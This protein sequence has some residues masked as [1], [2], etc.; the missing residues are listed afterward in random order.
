M[1]SIEGFSER[2]RAL[3]EILG[4]QVAWW[5]LGFRARRAV[6]RQ[7]RSGNR[8]P[9]PGIWSV[10]LG[11]ARH[12]LTA[13]LWWRR[14]RLAGATVLAIIYLLALAG[15]WMGADPFVAFSGALAICLPLAA[16]WSARQA[17]VARM[18]VALAPGPRP[19]RRSTLTLAIRTAGL[20]LSVGL[21]GGVVV[22]SLAH[23]H[24]AGRFCPPFAVDAPVRSWLRHNDGQTGVGCPAGDT[25]SAGGGARYTPWTAPD[26]SIR[27]GPDYV[28][29]GP[30][31]D[32]LMVMPLAIFAAW[33]AEGG[34]SG[35]LG[36]PIE[37]SADHSVDYVNFRGGAIVLPAGGTPQVLLGRRHSVARE[38]SGPCE[39]L[40][41]PCITRAS[42][43]PAG[44]RLSWRYQAADAFNVAWWPENDTARRSRVQ[45]EAAGYELTVRDLNPATTYLVEVQACEKHFVRR[46][47]CTRFS[48][49]VIVRVP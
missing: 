47:T 30:R 48:P 6:I 22:V 9:D 29:Y 43:D 39:V 25:L 26:R 5:Q 46:S 40:D 49:P 17:R 11:W 14:V 36:E 44:V 18:L 35:R 1:L 41:Y 45:R 21:A 23:R 2:H 16:G 27:F 10:A 8:F 4:A 15:E 38:S 3:A 31:P 20:L 13:P 37:E 42:A 34:P 33:T 28:M 12:W 24:P 19:D 7:A 32:S